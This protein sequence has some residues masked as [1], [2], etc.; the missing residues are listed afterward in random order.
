[1]H[2]HRS[3]EREIDYAAGTSSK[4]LKVDRPGIVEVE[5]HTLDNLI[6]MLEVR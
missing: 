5:S 1:M 6:V 4:L 3:P 2:I